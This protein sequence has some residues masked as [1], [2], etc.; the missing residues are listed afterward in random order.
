M[1][2]DIRPA[3]EWVKRRSCRVHTFLR[4]RAHPY[5]SCMPSSILGDQKILS[6]FLSVAKPFAAVSSRSPEYAG[7]CVRRRVQGKQR[8]N[9]SGSSQKAPP[10]GFLPLYVGCN[11]SERLR[12]IL[13]PVA[14]V[15]HPQFVE[16]MRKVEEEF[17]FDYRGGITIPI[18]SADFHEVW[19]LVTTADD[20]NGRLKC[21]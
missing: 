12:R 14:F 10:K 7:Q 1:G 11:E 5:S 18:P 17:G 16:L 4:R 8:E 13:V 19:T 2:F 6:L 9:E 20:G 21:I 3:C 15:N